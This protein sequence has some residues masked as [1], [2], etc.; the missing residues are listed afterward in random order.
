MEE[1]GLIWASSPRRLP[2]GTRVRAHDAD[3]LH[4]DAVVL[5]TMTRLKLDLDTF[6]QSLPSALPGRPVLITTALEP[7]TAS[8]P[9]V[10]SGPRT[11]RGRRL[12]RLTVGYR[13]ERSG[14]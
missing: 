6:E 3:G 7:H 4:A 5:S 1:Q 14:R 2:K 13:R 12:V 10:E 11:W 8:R 9:V